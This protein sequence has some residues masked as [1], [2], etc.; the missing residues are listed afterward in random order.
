MA[1]KIIYLT[2]ALL[3]CSACVHSKDNYANNSLVYHN[4]TLRAAMERIEEHKLET[5]KE[6]EEVKSVSVQVKEDFK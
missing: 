6:L 5:Q 1:N 2:F 4:V 3:F